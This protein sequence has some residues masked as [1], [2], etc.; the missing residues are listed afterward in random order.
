MVGLINAQ[1][2]QQKYPWLDSKLV[3]VFGG[4]FDPPHVGHLILAEEAL[5]QLGLREVLWVLTPNP[6][7]KLNQSIT[8]TETRQRM[9]LAAINDQPRFRFSSVDIDR[10]PPH[11][12]VD[13]IRILTSLEPD[14]KF[15][16]LIGG[17]SLHDLPSWHLPNE[18]I[19]LSQNI[20]VLRRP[21]D[22]INLEKLEIELPGVSDKIRWIDA[23]PIGIAASAIRKKIRFG[24]AYRYYLL[25]PVYKIINKENLYKEPR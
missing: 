24:Q 19:N 6:P 2:K 22:H 13:T 21:D 8:N 20:G 5:Y 25:P 14:V 23:P 18:L 11:Y 3:G 7:H 16:Y 17:D 1:K 9:V 15:V 12:A 10:S 4:T